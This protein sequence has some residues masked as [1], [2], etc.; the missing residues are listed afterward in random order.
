M[1]TEGPIQVAASADDAVEFID[2]SGFNSVGVQ[3]DIVD[4][5]TAN[6][7]TNAGFRFQSVDIA[8]GA[9]IDAVDFELLGIF[10]GGNLDANIT[11]ND[12]DNAVDFSSD[13]DVTTR[14]ASAST[15]ANT[16][17]IHSS[18]FP[19]GSFASSSTDLLDMNAIIQEVI[20]R[21]SWSSGNAIVMLAE[22]N[23]DGGRRGE[24]TFNVRA[25]DGVPSEA[26]RITI[27]FTGGGGGPAVL[28]SRRLMSGTGR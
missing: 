24:E 4:S 12:V 17:W 27:D 15:A 16:Q 10:S 7:S 1:T 21:G 20:D 6:K 13:A 19:G 9:T 5:L 28:A 3:I 2:G 23:T 25:Y 14:I 22:G 26:A 18:H 11:A 8:G